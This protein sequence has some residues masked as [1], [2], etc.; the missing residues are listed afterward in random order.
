MPQFQITQKFADVIHLQKLAEPIENLQL[1]DD[2][3]IDVFYLRNNEPV[4]I[5]VHAITRFTFFIPFAE[6]KSPEDIIVYFGILLKEIFVDAEMP[7]YIEQVNS[8]FKSPLI[9]CNAKNTD[10]LNHIHDF[11][12]HTLSFCEAKNAAESVDWNEVAAHINSMPISIQS[13]SMSSPA[14]L[15]SDFLNVEQLPIV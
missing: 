9:F 14:K 13:R 6:V 10:V 1:L 11:I 4:A 3:F 2:W 15:M 7:D 5:I 12:K 8:I